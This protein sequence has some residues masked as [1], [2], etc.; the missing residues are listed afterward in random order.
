MHSNRNWKQFSFRCWDSWSKNSWRP[1]FCS[2]P[3][4]DCRMWS[5]SKEQVAIL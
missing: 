4:Y 2:Y 1:E 5:I 3:D